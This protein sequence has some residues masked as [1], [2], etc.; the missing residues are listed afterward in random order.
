MK[1][2][3][4]GRSST[5]PEQLYSKVVILYAAALFLGIALLQFGGS[6]GRRLGPIV[7]LLSVG[8]LI[9]RMMRAWSTARELRQNAEDA[10]KREILRTERRER[11]HREKNQRNLEK[12]HRQR[13]SLKTRQEHAEKRRLLHIAAKAESARQ[14]ERADLIRSEAERLRSLPLERLMQAVREAFAQ[15]GD[16]WNDEPGTGFWK[17]VLIREQTGAREMIVVISP[18]KQADTSEIIAMEA[19]RRDDNCASGRLISVG[20]FSPR[21]VRQSSRLPITLLDAHLL[22]DYLI[23]PG[24]DSSRS[25]AN[26]QIAG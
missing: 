3:T 13:N 10:A 20:G 2:Q 14:L 1:N 12:G 19:L 7:L 16:R 5:E 25:V 17:A 24:R 11:G 23:T 8:G 26:K 18:P 6:D 22:A 4:A 21:A 9:R 15:S